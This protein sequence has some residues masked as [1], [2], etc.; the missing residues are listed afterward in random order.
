MQAGSA[1]AWLTA[2]A[3]QTEVGSTPAQVSAVVQT[4]LAASVAATQTGVSVEAAGTQTDL[5]GGLLTATVGTQ[6]AED[7]AV[8]TPDFGLGFRWRR[9]FRHERR[10]AY[11]LRV[12]AA[13]TDFLLQHAGLWPPQQ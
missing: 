7:A 8:Q 11:L 2:A 3:V 5:T 9:L 13:L 10:L 6:T 12:R 4:E 1:A